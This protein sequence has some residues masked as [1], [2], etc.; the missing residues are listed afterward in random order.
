[1]G[2]ARIGV[3]SGGINAA[4]IARELKYV[5]D[6]SKSEAVHFIKSERGTVL[7]PIIKQACAELST[8]KQSIFGHRP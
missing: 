4:F 5:L 1:M 6:R 8:I 2:F 7:A 3:A